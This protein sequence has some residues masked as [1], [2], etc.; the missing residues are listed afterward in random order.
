MVED[1]EPLGRQVERTLSGAIREA[2]F[3]GS[4]LRNLAAMAKLDTPGWVVD[5]APLDLVTLVERV[6]ARHQPP[7]RASGV[8]IASAVPG[9][10]VIIEA[11]ATLLEQALSNLVDNA[12]R[13]NR[14]GGHV[15]VT[16]DRAA[17]RFVLRVVD[18]GPGVTDAD[19]AELGTREF[20]S[21]EARSRRPEGQGLG[22]DIAGGV[23]RRLAFEM[24]FLRSP[25]GGL[26]VEI[27]GPLGP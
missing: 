11:D 1:D 19:M 25:A 22:L 13:Y 7:A 18:D 12:V 26:G 17:D 23:V 10:P 20:R 21:E 16:L 2:H 27:R 9:A 6:V 15:G 14:P 8:E 3:A 5:M 24:R 4:I